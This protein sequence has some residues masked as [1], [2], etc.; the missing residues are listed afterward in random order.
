MHNYILSVFFPAELYNKL[1]GTP[2][3][4]IREEGAEENICSVL[5]RLTVGSRNLHNEEFRGFYHWTNITRVM[6]IS[7]RMGGG[8]AMGESG[9]AYEILEWK[10]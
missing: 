10:T 5:R 6:T 1:E 2:T 8:V 7:R 4:V 9:V 3:G